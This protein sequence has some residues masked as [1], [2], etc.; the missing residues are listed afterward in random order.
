LTAGIPTEI[1]RET[2]PDKWKRV[3]KVK[4]PKKRIFHID[5]EKLLVFLGIFKS[6]CRKKSSEAAC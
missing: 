4:I 1:L 2:I 6:T 5:K 3:V